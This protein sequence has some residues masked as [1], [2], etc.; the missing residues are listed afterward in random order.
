MDAKRS[1]RESAAKFETAHF[2]AGHPAYRAHLETLRVL[3][4]DMS[5]LI[6]EDSARSSRWL[7]GRK[8]ATGAVGWSTR[9]FLSL[10][11]RSHGKNTSDAVLEAAKDAVRMALVHQ[12]YMALETSKG[13][14]STTVGGRGRYRTEEA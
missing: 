4:C 8:P 7:R 14:D 10:R 3:L 13:S 5:L 11:L 2:T 6:A 1:M 9:F 12:E